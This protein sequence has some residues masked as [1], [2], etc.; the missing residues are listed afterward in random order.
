M[1]SHSAD[2]LLRDVGARIAELRR[3]RGLTQGMLAERLD[4]S[5]KHLQRVEAGSE[6]LTLRT[7]HQFA[8]ALGVGVPALL[9]PPVQVPRRRGRPRLHAAGAVVPFAP[10]SIGA[11]LRSVVP[12]LTL[13][14]RDD[15]SDSFSD[16]RTLDWVALPSPHRASG[17]FVVR[18]I[19]DSM[20]P[21]IAGG[22]LVLLRVGPPADLDGATILV[23]LPPSDGREAIYVLKRV[24][25]VATAGSGVR[26]AFLDSLNPAVEP[27]LVVFDD[28]ID[29]VIVATFVQLL[30]G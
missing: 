27:R 6:N 17:H 7:M 24:R 13:V 15:E 14:A 25:L 21:R 2:Q 10:P 1:D 19:G 20:A 8:A 26:S 4:V 29:P 16:G 28:D 9:Q 3:V 18:V 11:V 30:A 22:A 5:D 23:R 12:L